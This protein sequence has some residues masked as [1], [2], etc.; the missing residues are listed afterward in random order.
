MR[1]FFDFLEN[2]NLDSGKEDLELEEEEEENSDVEEVIDDLNEASNN[3]LSATDREAEKK[4]DVNSPQRQKVKTKKSPK[5][6]ELALGQE[7]IK[8][9]KTQQGMLL[10]FH[11]F[12][13]SKKNFEIIFCF[14]EFF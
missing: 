1:L 3:P 10:H 13:K 9:K 6:E 2:K 4:S 12:F 14:H 8:S 5:P 7:M 11:E